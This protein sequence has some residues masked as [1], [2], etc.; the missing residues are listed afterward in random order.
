VHSRAHSVSADRLGDVLE[1]L[2]APILEGSLQLA[3]DLA[4]DLAGDQNTARISKG[5]EPGRDIDAVSVT[6]P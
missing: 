4:V 6:S 3:L 5:F 1:L 2:F